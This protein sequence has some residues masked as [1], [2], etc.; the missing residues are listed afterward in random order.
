MFVFCLI[1][2]HI[3]IL[4]KGKKINNKDYKKFIKPVFFVSHPLKK[5]NVLTFCTIIQ[6]L[7]KPNKKHILMNH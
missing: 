1:F 3:I 6:T 5:K 4:I 7:E 2:I